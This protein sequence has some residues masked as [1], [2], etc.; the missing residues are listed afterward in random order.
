[1][2]LTKRLMYVIVI[3]FGFLFLSSFQKERIK[4][5]SN[6]Y[7]VWANQNCEMVQTKKYTLIFSREADK[8]KVILRRNI[9]K[10]DTIFSEFVLGYVF[11]NEEKS[12]KKIKHIKNTSVLLDSLLS[13]KDNKLE[14]RLDSNEQLLD[15]VEKIDI[16]PP[17]DMLSAKKGIIGKCLQTWQLGTVEH[18]LD[19]DDFWIEIG[20]NKHLYI[21]LS[22]QNQLYCR[23]A[24]IR[25]NEK[26]SV[27]SQNIRLMFNTN[28]NETTIFM[29][30]DNYTITKADININDSLFK[31]NVCSFEKGGIYWSFVSYKADTIRLN[32]CG[33]IYTFTKPLLSD[34]KRVEWF[35][36]KN[37]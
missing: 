1:M 29:D 6:Y 32:G 26:G 12:Y 24:R 36:Y 30:K 17:Y 8:I 18:K 25:S 4:D 5:R 19:V 16:C 31:P 14:L 20:T 28:N 37:Y 2:N 7:G 3:V 10:H 9:I 13:L 22:N 27:F 23:A 15:M 34:K 33:D 21:F 11:D 35:K